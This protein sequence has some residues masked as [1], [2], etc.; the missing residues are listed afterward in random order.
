MPSSG[1][2]DLSPCCEAAV[3]KFEA[4][5]LP[6]ICSDCGAELTELDSK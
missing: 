5:D 4:D 6:A 1:E 2:P 3:E